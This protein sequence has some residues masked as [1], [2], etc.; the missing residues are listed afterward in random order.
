MNEFDNIPTSSR[1]ATVASGGAGTGRRPLKS[2]PPPVRRQRAALKSALIVLCGSVVCGGVVA[3]ALGLSSVITGRPPNCAAM[4]SAAAS[5]PAGTA[6][7]TVIVGVPAIPPRWPTPPPATCARRSPR[8]RR[9]QP[10][11]QTSCSSMGPLVSAAPAVRLR[12]ISLRTRTISATTRRLHLRPAR[13][14][15]ALSKANTRPRWTRWPRRSAP[16]FSRRRRRPRATQAPTTFGTSLRE[17]TLSASMSS[18]ILALAAT[19]A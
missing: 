3:G 15:R 14:S 17:S 6:T 4:A 8:L 16:R 18:T 11:S 9:P 12:S 2:A 13:R 19:T 5:A 7:T 1:T 10:W